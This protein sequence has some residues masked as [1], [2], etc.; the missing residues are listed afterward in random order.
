MSNIPITG[1]AGRSFLPDASFVKSAMTLLERRYTTTI[2]TKT[3]KNNMDVRKDRFK[4]GER[5]EKRDD[6]L[7][8]QTYE[9]IL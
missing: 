4:S 9:E 5:P 8:E 6:T 3:L 7:C 2:H 1:H